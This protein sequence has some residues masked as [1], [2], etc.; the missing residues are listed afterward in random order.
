MDEFLHTCS[1]RHQ[2]QAPANNR[3]KETSIASNEQCEM[4]DKCVGVEG[5]GDDV[6]RPV[7]SPAREGAP[8]AG[9][10]A[11]RRSQTGRRDGRRAERIVAR[12][13]NKS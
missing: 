6:W 12:I 8:Y 7:L 2:H 3:R 13:W 1:M 9:P 11:A 10:R 4:F 5:S